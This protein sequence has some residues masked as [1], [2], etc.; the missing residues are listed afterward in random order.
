MNKGPLWS[1]ADFVNAIGVAHS[2]EQARRISDILGVSIDTRTLAKG[3]VFVALQG[4]QCHGSSLVDDAFAKGASAVMVES[5]MPC[6]PSFCVPN[7]RNAL[8]DLALAARKRYTGPVVA[9]TGSTGKTTVKD[10]IGHALRAQRSTFVSRGSFNNSLGVSVSLANLPRDVHYAVFEHGMDC[11]GQIQ[12]LVQRVQ[13]TVAMVTNVSCQHMENFNTVQDIARAKAEIMSVESVHTVVLNHDCDYY[14]VMRS[15]AL[16]HQRIITFGRSAH[17]T[18]RIED[19]TIDGS[20]MAVHLTV[21]GHPLTCHVPHIGAYWATNTA[22]ILAAVLA[23]G[24]DIHQAAQSLSSFYPPVGRGHVMHVGGITVIDD[25]YNAAPKAMEKA[26]TT[27]SHYPAKGKKY[28]F[29]GAMHELGTQEEAMHRALVPFVQK[30]CDHA[31]VCGSAFRFMSNETSVS[32][33]YADNIRDMIQSCMA[34]LKPGDVVLVKGARGMETFAFIYALLVRFHG[35]NAAC[36]YPLRV[37]ISADTVQWVHAC[38]GRA[39]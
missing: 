13:P 28:G 15:S 30:A 1:Y 24:G 17:A 5:A 22:S 25:S 14:N 31:W 26:L 10:G 23:V 11:A 18:V 12:S 6:V 34:C 2:P 7:T 19:T 32:C 39:P 9:V 29:L 16:P 21:Q 37:Y 38:F 36:T 3:D 4:G 35:V 20:M 27:L 33:T 8:W